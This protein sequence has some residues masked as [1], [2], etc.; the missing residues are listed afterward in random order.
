MKRKNLVPARPYLNKKL[1]NKRIKILFDEEKTKTELAKIVR[2]AREK[3]GLSQRELAA[4]AKTT[5]GVIARLEMGNDARMP[6]LLLLSRLLRAAGA[7][8]ELKCIFDKAA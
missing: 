3:A 1:K 8:L 7:H 2:T 5:Q 6:T 4:K